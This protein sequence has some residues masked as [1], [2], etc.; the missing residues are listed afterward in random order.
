MDRKLH[1]V[2][3]ADSHQMHKQLTVV[4]DKHREYLHNRPSVFNSR[5]DADTFNGAK[6]GRP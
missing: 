6:A 5:I 3:V 4:A 2:T 1:L